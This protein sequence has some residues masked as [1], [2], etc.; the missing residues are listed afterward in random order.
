MRGRGSGTNFQQVDNKLARTFTT[1]METLKKFRS[2]NEQRV[3]VEHQHVHV[4]PGGQAVVG[5]VTQTGSI[6]GFCGWTIK[7]P[8]TCSCR[9]LVR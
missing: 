7:Y 9:A 4:Y 8:D 1:Q 2:K 5:T 3:V 6:N